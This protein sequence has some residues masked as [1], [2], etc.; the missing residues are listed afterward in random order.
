MS[1]RTVLDYSD[2][3]SDLPRPIPFSCSIKLVQRFLHT[4]FPPDGLIIINVGMRF[5]TCPIDR[6]VLSTVWYGKLVHVEPAH[7]SS[8]THPT[9]PPCTFHIIPQCELYSHFGWPQEH[10][11]AYSSSSS[12]LMVY[13]FLF[14]GR[15]IP[16]VRNCCVS[17]FA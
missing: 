4:L 11:C 3:D 1:L 10:I 9:V 2:F 13:R 7:S 16:P 15:C 6:G 8:P 12:R 17:V 14:S 5:I